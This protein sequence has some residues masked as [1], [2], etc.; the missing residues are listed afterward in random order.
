M[1]RVAEVT[2]IL[3]LP[4]LKEEVNRGTGFDHLPMCQIGHLPTT[5]PAEID[6]VRA[7][8]ARGRVPVAF[9]DEFGY[10]RFLL[11]PV[12]MPIG[13]LSWNGGLIMFGSLPGCTPVWSVI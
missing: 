9:W 7:S 2:F 8:V 11:R 3:V 4:Y 6:P 13:G 12:S 5:D 1:K 10:L